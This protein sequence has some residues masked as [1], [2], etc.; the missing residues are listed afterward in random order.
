[1][2]ID[3]WIVA[4]AFLIPSFSTTRFAECRPCVLSLPRR[5]SNPWYFATFGLCASFLH[6]PTQQRVGYVAQP[7]LGNP[8]GDI[9]FCPR[10]H[11][12]LDEEWRP[13]KLR[14]CSIHAKACAQRWQP[15]C[16]QEVIRTS[17]DTVPSVHSPAIP[18]KSEPRLSSHAVG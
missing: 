10:N 8:I 1:M 13:T 7:S 14:P 18:N 5:D 3:S 17:L 16:G 9:T 4:G 12:L 11:L 6:G 2:T 15:S